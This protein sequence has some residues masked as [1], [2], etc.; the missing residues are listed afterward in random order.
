MRTLL[1]EALPRLA[2]IDRRR[3]QA[4]G[5]KA[6]CRATQEDSD[7]SVGLPKGARVADLQP[8]CQW[9]ATAGTRKAGGRV[10]GIIRTYLPTGTGTS[11]LRA[12]APL[13][14]RSNLQ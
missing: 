3:S 6:T 11:S 9:R 7:A 8:E 13:D 2:E 10:S 12:F 4:V 14:R 5:R 1:H